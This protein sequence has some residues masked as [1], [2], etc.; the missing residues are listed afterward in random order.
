M[1]WTGWSCASPV[2]A[3][4]SITVI[5]F[6]KVKALSGFYEPR[7]GLCWAARA[8]HLRCLSGQVPCSEHP[9]RTSSQSL[10]TV[11]QDRAKRPS[12]LP[13]PYGMPHLVQPS[14]H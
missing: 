2:R 8:E 6:G 11:L 14:L 13:R 7:V 10:H 9:L 4:F 5:V 1:R 3:M 12:P